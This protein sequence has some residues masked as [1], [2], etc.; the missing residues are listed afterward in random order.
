[1]NANDSAQ[2]A[3]LARAAYI[4]A[5][6][7]IAKGEAPSSPLHE[8]AEIASKADINARRQMLRETW[9]EVRPLASLHVVGRFTRRVVDD[10]GI[11]E[12]QHVIAHCTF[13]GCGAT[14]ERKCASGLVQEHIARFAVV[15]LHRDVFHMRPRKVE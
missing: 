8:L 1:M 15:H 14:F 13:A 5:A 6:E 7:A 12:E 9:V 11:P 10:D 4:Q 2:R 3:L